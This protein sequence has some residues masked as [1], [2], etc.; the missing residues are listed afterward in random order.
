MSSDRAELI[1]LLQTIRDDVAKLNPDGIRSWMIKEEL[2]K[3]GMQ[4]DE[5]SIRALFVEIGEPLTGAIPQQRTG[6]PKPA[7]ARSK[8][9]EIAKRVYEVAA[10]MKQY[11]PD[12]NLFTDYIIRPIDE[13]L[14]L[15][16]NS[17]R[18][19]N[20]KY[21]ITQGKQGTGKTMGHLYYAHS[22]QLPFFLFSC[23]EDFKLHKLFGEKTIVGGNVVFKEGL[24]TLAIQQPSVI[25]FDE[26]NYISNENS[27][28]FHALL[29]NRELFVK[30]ADNGNGKIYR[31]HPDCKIGFA[32]NPKSAKYIG[33]NVKPSNFLGRCTYITYP[34]F[35]KK[36][37]KTAVKKRFPNLVEDD[38]NKFTA[39]YF[40]CI[41]AIDQ[42]KL[43]V[44]ISIRQL[45]NVI[46]LYNHGMPLKNAIE[47]G[48][49]SILEAVSLPTSKETFHKIAEAVWADLMNQNIDNKVGTMDNM[50]R[51]MRRRLWG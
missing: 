1:T 41:E 31:L 15:H 35:T 50:L 38:A 43:P 51:G 4:M 46:D 34:E 11:I 7:P 42:A 39:F 20:W 33:G 28:D 12:P 23:F 14:A 29:Q 18:P 3:R 32:Q 16:Y 21:P 25:L 22:Q 24:L 10:N 36:E 30:D 48:M 9:I 49:T 13:R 5:N 45:N 8:R 47:D 40:G 44:D 6:T 37:I 26:V 19:M 27:V 17:S 2:T